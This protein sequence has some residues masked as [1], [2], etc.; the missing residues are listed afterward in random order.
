MFKGAACGRHSVRCSLVARLSGDEA[1]TDAAA[2]SMHSR[3]HLA[4]K[5]WGGSATMSGHI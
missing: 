4:T 3:F 5:I 2:L 1:S